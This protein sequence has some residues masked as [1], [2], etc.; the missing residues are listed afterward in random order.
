MLNGE[1]GFYIQM[2]VTVLTAGVGLVTAHRFTSK[3]D[4]KNAERLRRIDSL[5]TA[6]F[7]FIRTGIDGVI[8]KKDHEGKLLPTAKNLEDAVA[9]IHLYGTDEQSILADEYVL[10]LSDTGSAN[11]TEL[12]DSLRKTIRN[13]LGLTQLVNVPHYLRINYSP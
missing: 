2:V 9:V 8:V 1:T 5:S 4:I 12:V 6:Y 7:A 3:R 13:E 10:K 11:S